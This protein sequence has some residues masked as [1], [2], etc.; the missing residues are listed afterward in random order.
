MDLFYLL[1]AFLAGACAP[2]QAG[3]N[4]ELSMIVRGPMQ[5]ALISFAVGTLALGVYCVL[6]RSPWPAAEIIKSMPWWLWTGGFLGAFLVASTIF[7]APKVGAVSLM[8]AMITGQMIISLFLDH[9]GWLAYP[10]YPIN[11]WRILGILL[12]VAGVVTIRAS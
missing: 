8:V 2:T 5:A 6:A 12:V 4:S 1:L 10:V 3:I 9:Y 7:V 11:G